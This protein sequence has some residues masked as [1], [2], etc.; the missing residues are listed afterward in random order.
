MHGYKGKKFF[1][2]K[3]GAIVESVTD[4]LNLGD[5]WKNMT[6]NPGWHPLFDIEGNYAGYKSGKNGFVAVET[7]IA[8][9][10]L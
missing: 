3:T 10:N 6:D 4:G 1:N 8:E 2:I 7:V 9:D 5:D